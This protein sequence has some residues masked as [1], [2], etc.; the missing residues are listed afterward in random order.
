MDWP[1]PER[2]G[3]VFTEVNT[4]VNAFHLAALAR[5]AELARAVGRESEAREFADRYDQTLRVFNERLF[6]TER[7]IYRDGVGT[8][9]ASLHSNLFPLAF[10]LVPAERRAECVAMAGRARDGL[11]GL[12]RA[13]LDGRAVREWRG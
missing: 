5:M 8:E 6:D 7:G 4:V 2:D 13:I 1:K 11:L 10:G 9:H 12:C 3:F